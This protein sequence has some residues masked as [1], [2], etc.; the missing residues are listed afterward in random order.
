VQAAVALRFLIQSDLGPVKL[1]PVLQ[2]LLSEFFGIMAEIDSDDLI[3]A[4]ERIV[5]EF[6]TEVAPFAIELCARLADSFLRITADISEEDE[7][8]SALAALECLRTIHT[9]LQAVSSNPELVSALE[10]ALMPMLVKA[11]DEEYLEYFEDIVRIVSLISYNAQSISPALQNLMLL[12]CQAFL[13][14][15]AID[16]FSSTFGAVLYH[17]SFG[18]YS[19]ALSLSLSLC[20]CV[21]DR[22]L[23]LGR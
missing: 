23:D 8:N 21:Y 9:S 7:E 11:C 15:W 16:F 1:L 10:S 14:D 6:R 19:L 13:D 3:G 12:L 4:L 20:V 18:T 2:P 17:A 5:S 22:Y